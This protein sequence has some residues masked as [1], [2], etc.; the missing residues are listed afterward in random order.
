VH[1]GCASHV[2]RTSFFLSF[3]FQLL[4]VNLI[5]DTLGAL[6][7]AT[8]PPTDNLMKRNP[9][10][11]RQVK[12]SEFIVDNIV[13]NVFQCIVLCI[14]NLKYSSA[15]NLL[16]QISCGETCLSRLVFLCYTIGFCLIFFFSNTFRISCRPFTK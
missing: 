13:C 3:T 16:L 12:V 11:R 10:G 6:A 7:L 9:V 8:E 14:L 4:W 1:P 15:G 2:L 5:M